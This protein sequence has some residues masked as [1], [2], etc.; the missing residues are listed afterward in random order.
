MQNK[1][2]NLFED[3]LDEEVNTQIKIGFSDKKQCEIMQKVAFTNG[4]L[5]QLQYFAKDKI[6][7]NI[8][9]QTS[10]IDYDQQ[11]SYPLKTAE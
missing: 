9:V 10:N 2:N 3:K 4:Q 6:H 1:K 8:D 11:I 7:S 5:N